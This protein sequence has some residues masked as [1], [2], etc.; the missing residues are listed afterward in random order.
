MFFCNYLKHPKVGPSN[1]LAENGIKLFVVGRKN[2]LFA[3]HPNGAQALSVYY[4][5]IETAKA[6]NVRPLNYLKYV[7]SHI[8]NTPGDR[9]VDLLP[10]NC[11]L[12]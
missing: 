7:F 4:S 6:N 5:L 3:G 2:F 9:I 10:W 8:N 12:A 11:D 1:Q